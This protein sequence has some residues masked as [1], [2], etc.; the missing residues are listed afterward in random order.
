MRRMIVAAPAVLFLVVAPVGSVQAQVTAHHHV[1]QVMDPSAEDLETVGFLTKALGDAGIANEYAG[2]AAGGA[3]AP[4]DLASMRT[5]AGNVLHA[6]DP[7]KVDEGPGFDFG[8]IPS[9]RRVIDHLEMAAAAEDATENVRTHARHVVASARNTLERAERMVELI[10]RIRSTTSAEEADRL[11]DELELLS[12]Q[13]RNGADADG[14]G[15][16]TWQEGEGGLY[17]A[18]RHMA[19]LIAG[20][21]IES[22]GR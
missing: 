1:L 14:D 22:K 11:A 10:D 12:R 18:E 13:L 8:V 9:V 15:R 5:H 21:G 3:Q 16:V 4:G 6:L 17:Q 2:Y 20:E 7:S 19:L